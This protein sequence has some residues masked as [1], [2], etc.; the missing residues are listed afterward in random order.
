[1]ALTD[2]FPFAASRPTQPPPAGTCDCHTHIFGPIDRYP[3]GAGRSYTPMDASVDDLKSMLQT[4]ELDRVILVQPSPYR[5]D[6]RCLIDA[7]PKFGA[8]ARG[9]AVIDDDA[10]EDELRRL[11]AA[12][13]C[14]IR[15]NIASGGNSIDLPLDV[16]IA[17]LAARIAGLGWHLQLFVKSDD[18][19]AL[20]PTLAE[21][22]VPLVVD[23]MG[24]V[25][26]TVV[27]LHP[28]HDTLLRLLDRGHCWVKLSGAY[29]LGGS[30]TEFA[31]VEPL[32]RSLV[33]RCPE[34]MVWGS[35][36]PHTP[37]HAGAS[38]GPDT[39]RPFRLIDTGRQLDLLSDWVPDPATRAR[40]LVQNPARLYGFG[41]IS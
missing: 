19:V 22:P 17:R 15:L 26:C 8:A 24:L 29:R 10:P 31:P 7:L 41:D 37:H 14:G 13:I 6:N 20:E 1:M 36:W 16:R 23:H 40:I 3:Y 2:R 12:G 38:D 25:D 5:A 11:D 39:R 33:A 28:A 27:P 18:L 21:L 4:L 9:V 32:A 35:D 30:D 34:R